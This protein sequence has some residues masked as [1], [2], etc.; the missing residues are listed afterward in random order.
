LED[1]LPSR[2][3]FG[4]I[5]TRGHQHDAL[6]L[7]HWVQQPFAFLG[8]I[9]SQRKRRIIFE[10]FVHDRIASEE[11]LAR[12]AC[13]VGIDIRAVS[14]PEIAISVVAQLVERRAEFLTRLNG[15]L[16]ATEDSRHEARDLTENAL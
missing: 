7:K 10:Q 5:V 15:Q 11:Q 16:R 2:P 14:V 8:M 13:P 3:T 1:P 4:L 6:V 9:G 12:V